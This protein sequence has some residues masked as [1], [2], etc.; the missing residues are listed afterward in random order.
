MSHPRK[1]WLAA[2]ARDQVATG[3]S[4]EE[5]AELP[6]RA[7]LISQVV[8]HDGQQPQD[9]GPGRGRLP[10]SSIAIR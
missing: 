10:C 1:D 3:M 6:V 7:E 8:Q 9:G 5:T 2:E 4:Y